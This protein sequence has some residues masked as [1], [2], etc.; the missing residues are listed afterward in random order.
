[1]PT[2]LRAPMF[3]IAL[4]LPWL[5]ASSPADFLLFDNFEDELEGPIQGQD[6]WVSLG[7][8]NR[9]VSDPG[10][11]G[12]QVLYVPSASS[13]L[14][15]ALGPS[16]LV[17]PDGTARMLFMRLRVVERQTFSVGLSPLT[18]PS[19]Y[20]DFAPELGLASNA[21][22]LDLRI[23][24]DDGDNYETLVQLVADVWYNVW[25]RTDTAANQ[26]EV[27]INMHPG[28]GATAAHKL[29]A[30]DG[31]ETFGFRAGDNAALIT[32]YIKTSG[33]NSGFG[34]AYFDDIFIET[35]PATN[36]SNPTAAPIVA[37]VGDLD[38][39]GVVDFFDID[40]FVVALAGEGVY[41]S[42]Y[43]DCRWLNGDADTNGAV[44]FFDIDPFVTRLGATCP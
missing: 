28:G 16:G 32:F 2:F 6:G 44:D 37:C 39:N 14:R 15:K 12:N 26:S 17:V 22:N 35:T 8:D 21:P 25:V 1:M 7:G 29:V 42:V 4:S 31:D 5:A 18:S 43:P 33:G 23:W 40:A 24:D 11:G 10:G 19:E 20:S 9:V 13:I 34:P 27:W 30:D 36:L 38:C 41:G 3:V